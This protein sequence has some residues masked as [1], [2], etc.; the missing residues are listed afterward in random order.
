V[1]RIGI[2]AGNGDLPAM[3]IKQ[4]EKTGIEPF[5]VMIKNFADYEKYKKYTNTIVSFGHVGKTIS[6]FKKNN[7]KEVIFAGGVKK[8]NLKQI[9]PDWAGY[10]L[11]FRL[12]KTKLQGDDSILR[13][14]I[15]FA[16]ERGLKIIPVHSFLGQKIAP[17]KVGQVNIPNNDY[18]TDI[19]LGVKVLKQL[20]TLDIG[21]SIVIQNGMVIGIE[22]I[23]GTQIL[24]ERCNK[25]K[26]EKG[27]K[28]ILVKMKKSAQTDKADLPA[29][30]KNTIEQLKNSNFAGVVVDCDNGII[31]NQS[32]TIDL[33]NKNKIFIYGY[34]E[35]LCQ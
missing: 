21:Q 27:R 1:K 14:I 8:P 25:I 2:I 16:E 9:L 3:V 10:G 11:F 26:Y 22:C 30:G 35:V 28:P 17:G 32:E 18:L 29:I 5:V 12:L 15:K 13:E 24:I 33:A 6:F 23:E 4:C 20:G 7:V 19:D 31:I 34:R